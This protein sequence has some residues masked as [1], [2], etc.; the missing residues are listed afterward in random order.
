[1]FKNTLAKNHLLHHLFHYADEYKEEVIKILRIL[2]DKFRKGFE[3]QKGAIFGFGEAANDDTGHVLKISNLQDKSLLANAPISN[4]GSERN[5]GMLNTELN[6]RGRENFKTSSQNLVLNKSADL[7]TDYSNLKKFRKPAKD[8][9]EL[10]QKW[11]KKM[12][13]LEKQGLIDKE[14]ISL[15]EERKKISD[16]QF[17]KTQ[18]PPGPFTSADEV[19][20]YMRNQRISDTEKNQRLYSEVRYAKLSTSNMKR[21][22]VLFRL[23]KNYKNLCNDDYATNLKLYF[24]CIN[25]VSTITLA[26][27]SYILT[28]LSAAQT[29]SNEN[30]STDLSPEENQ[31]SPN[32]NLKIGS[33]IAGVWA[34]EADSAGEALTWYLGVVESLSE[35][36]A[37][38]SYLV[39]TKSNDKT[40]WMYPDTSDIGSSNSFYT[41]YDQIIA[42]DLSN[43]VKYS[44]VT[45]IRCHM[46]PNTITRLD[47]LLEEYKLKEKI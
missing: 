22:S 18:D 6:F 24:G 31:G 25:S 45:I 9:E 39:Q 12:E 27:L 19:D 35:S 33:H 8:I 14:A 46:E 10:R 1:M 2:L 7:I 34:N 20:S 44:C 43:F 40:H 29:S 42:E 15:S 5:V 4:I 32:S 28:G 23:K 3:K 36:G 37:M 26:D 17:L 41:P 16:L 13:D 21:S 30:V 11:N 38:V 47:Q